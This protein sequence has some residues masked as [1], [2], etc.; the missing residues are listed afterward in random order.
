MSDQLGEVSKPGFVVTLRVRT[1]H[2]RGVQF[3]NETLAAKLRQD[4][5][6][7][8]LGFHID[9]VDIITF[10]LL[11]QADRSGGLGKSAGWDR[12][13]RLGSAGRGGFDGKE[14]GPGPTYGGK[15]PS[16]GGRV[17]SGMDFGKGGSATGGASEVVSEFVDPLTGEDMS[18]DSVCVLRFG[19][20]LGEPEPAAA[21]Q[22]SQGGPAGQPFFGAKG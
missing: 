14:M 5:R 22:E 7:A 10:D 2:A 1:P 8:G 15:M 20:V 9:R 18:T 17:A 21:E 4:G 12:S 3:V 13:A 16:M 11:S 19:I 6:R